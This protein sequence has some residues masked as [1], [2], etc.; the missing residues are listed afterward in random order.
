ML[1][2]PTLRDFRFQK[3]LKPFLCQPIKVEALATT[4]ADFHLLNTL[5]IQ[6][7]MILSIFSS[8]GLL[9]LRL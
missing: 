6:T 1:G 5:D 4:R 3:S 9:F 8:F 7:S 2:L